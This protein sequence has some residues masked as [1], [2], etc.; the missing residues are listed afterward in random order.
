MG[1]ALQRNERATGVDA[2]REAA[3]GVRGV[4][5]KR[6]GRREKGKV[7]GDAHRGAERGGGVRNCEG[8]GESTCRVYEP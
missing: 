8:R 3:A 4:A 1:R 5:D 7:V 6:R 2:E